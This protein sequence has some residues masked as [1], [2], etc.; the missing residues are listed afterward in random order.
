MIEYI[1]Y[2][3]VEVSIWVLFFA[4][5]IAAILHLR[6]KR[7]RHKLG[8]YV[9]FI[10]YKL[11]ITKKISRKFVSKVHVREDNE[12]MVDLVKH[13]KILHNDDTIEHPVLL[14]K[15][16][17][18][19][20]Y[21][22]A[23]RLP[24]DVYLKVYSAFRSR[25][26]VYNTWK[27]EEERL[28]KENPNMSRAAL[29]E[30]VNAKVASPNADMG[31]HDTGGAID[32]ALCDKNRNDLDFGTK[33]QERHKKV[34]LTKEQKENRKMLK[35]FMKSQKFVNTPGRWWHFSYGDKTWAA[36]KGKRNGAFYG[37]VEKEFENIGYV[38]VVK[39]EI[40]SVNIK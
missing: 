39:T 23:D 38:K 20:L 15:S 16:V 6:S 19:K 26:T 25:I 22:V 37:A 21:K 24:D 27:S 2:N 4:F 10:F 18:M 1:K 3:F 32:V 8:Y 9:N 34:Y 35:N 13:P 29:L 17:A 36:Y 12:P 5:V 28:T 11:G 30:L 14:R 33:Y 31:G 40:K 7:N